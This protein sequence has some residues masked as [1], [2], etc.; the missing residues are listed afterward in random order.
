M[1]YRS[2]ARVADA[3]PVSFA[4]VRFGLF[5]VGVASI[6]KVALVLL[7]APEALRSA[8]TIIA[9]VGFVAFARVPRG[10]PGVY[11]ARAAAALAPAS[12]GVGALMLVPHVHLSPTWLGWVER[13][14]ELGLVLFL[15][16]TLRIGHALRQATTAWATFLMIAVC[17]AAILS[18]RDASLA[19]SGSLVV[20]TVRISP[21]ALLIT[22]GVCLPLRRHLRFADGLAIPDQSLSDA[23]GLALA[24]RLLSGV[25]SA[26]VVL[27]AIAGASTYTRVAVCAPPPS[28]SFLD[29][30]AWGV[31]DLVLVAAAGF[32]LALLGRPPRAMGRYFTLCGVG[33]LS[34]I[35]VLQSAHEGRAWPSQAVVVTL[36]YGQIVAWIATA[37]AIARVVAERVSTA[38]LDPRPLRDPFVGI[39]GATIFLTLVGMYVSPY[40]RRGVYVALTVPTLI[41]ACLFARQLASEVLSLSA[42]LEARGD[43]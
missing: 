18:Y 37:I 23:P 28:V 13:L 26:R 4:S 41:A 16:A 25:L 10:I 34:L 40:E 43:A 24:L 22:F 19:R 27:S 42:A 20:E 5:V 6:A 9:A 30:A 1:P 35:V 3:R 38:H 36:L 17:V 2:P 14:R 11:F 31:V 7:S 8:V 32:A 33:I 39:L 12:V 15:I 21:Y 29:Y